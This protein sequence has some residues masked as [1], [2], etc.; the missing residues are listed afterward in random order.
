MK[1]RYVVASALI[2]SLGLFACDHSPDGTTRPDPMICKG[3]SCIDFVSCETDDECPDAKMCVEGQCVALSFPICEGESCI[4]PWSCA[5]NDDCPD[6]SACVEGRCLVPSEGGCRSD[7]ECLDGGIC[8]D[9]ACTEHGCAADAECP[10]G[11]R[12]VEGECQP[13]AVFY[14]PP[15][16]PSPPENFVIAQQPTR[17]R[18]TPMTTTIEFPPNPENVPCPIDR[19]SIPDWAKQRIRDAVGVENPLVRHCAA[20]ERLDLSRCKKNNLSQ[21]VCVEGTIQ[22]TDLGIQH[23]EWLSYFS[24]LNELDLSFNQISDIRTL[25][26]LVNLDELNLGFNLLT[27]ALPL[28]CNS[29]LGRGD[30]VTLINNCLTEAWIQR[31]RERGIS[32]VTHPQDLDRCIAP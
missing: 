3:T 8:V 25:E 14:F 7:T 2:L 29:G 18:I 23:L 15:T 16:A 1:K 4:D 11:K 30:R 32:L 24:G 17:G 21:W 26:H 9:D 12:C 27:G 31:L 5:T 13:T 6:K 10:D 28:I 20:I 22:D 19:W